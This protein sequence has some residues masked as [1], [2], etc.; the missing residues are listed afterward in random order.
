MTIDNEP[1]FVGKDVAMALGYKDA[2]DALKKHV[3]EYD[4]AIFKPGE[5]P[6]LK[7]PNRRAYIIN[8][9]SLY[10]PLSSV[11]N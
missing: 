9:S 5:M 10:T 11:V 2:P 8:E 7:I 3:S 1:W 6:T 4:K